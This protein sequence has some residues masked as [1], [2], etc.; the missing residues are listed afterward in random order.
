MTNSISSSDFVSII[1]QLEH[2]GTVTFADLR[3]ADQVEFFDG[4]ASGA[5]GFL[6]EGGEFFE[7]IH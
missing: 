2:N 1:Q 4:T 5:V 6:L 3:L 7:E